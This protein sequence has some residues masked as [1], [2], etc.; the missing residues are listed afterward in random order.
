LLISYADDTETVIVEIRDD[1]K[2][3][4]INNYACIGTGSTIALATLCQEDWISMESLDAA[5]R[6]YTAKKAAE[7]DP[8]VGWGT[9]F[10]ILVNGDKALDITRE[11][12]KLI[13]SKTKRRNFPRDL[14][15]KQ[16]F[17]E[18]MGTEP[19]VGE[20][21]TSRGRSTRGHYIRR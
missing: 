2:V 19:D 15:A 18:V 14:I 12:R 13:W 3:I 9:S 6:L 10:A 21:E 1:G 7:K 4:W 5:A 11:G 20:K 16:E 8:Y 17:F